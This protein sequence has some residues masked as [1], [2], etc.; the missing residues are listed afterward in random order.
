[1]S[2]TII[3]EL[4]VKP[5]QMATAKQFFRDILADTRAYDGCE[6]VKVVEHSDAPGTL[7]LV[8]GWETRAKYE[9][10][11]AWRQESGAL[12]KLGPMLAA[13]PNLRFFDTVG[14]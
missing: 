14:V 2:C 10:Y 4:S 3:L 5:D 8:E 7:V 1:M 13:E 11:F 9:T 6:S 12:D